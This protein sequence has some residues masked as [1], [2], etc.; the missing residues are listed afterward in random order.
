MRARVATRHIPPEV[1]ALVD[2]RLGGRFCVD[3]RSLGLET[4]RDVPLEADHLQALARGGD[5]SH[6]NL[7]WRC[8][9]HNRAKGAKRAGAEPGRPRW[10][11]KRK[12]HREDA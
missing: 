12:R 3:C 2:E 9:S 11:R 7:T 8:R 5:N 10:D 4:P 1:L 6:L